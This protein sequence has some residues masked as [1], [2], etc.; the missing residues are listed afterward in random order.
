MVPNHAA[1]SGSRQAHGSR[2][3]RI[4]TIL[5]GVRPSALS[6]GT[7]FGRPE[8]ARASGALGLCRTRYAPLQRL[9]EHAH[10]EPYLCLA[11]T[12]SFAERSQGREFEVVPGTVVL[13]R[14]GE[15]HADRF[16]PAPASCLNVSF[17]RA[18][19][20][21]L[22]AWIDAGPALYAPRAALGEIGARLAREFEAPDEASELALEGLTLELLAFFTRREHGR[23]RRAPPWM[24]ALCERLRQGE[25]PSLL[26][27]ASE[28]GVH[29]A[30]L[31]RAFRR[32]HGC[33][34]GEYARRARLA[35]AMT[36]LRA[37]DAPLSEVA[38]RTGFA[39]QSH[40]TRALRAAVGLAPA[41]YRRATRGSAAG[42]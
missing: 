40:L 19:R 37:S 16:G 8:D 34:P 3:R 27:L 12:G 18:W 25:R 21:R 7:Y 9:P 35:R 13:H 26:T 24:P 14:A 33:S 38:L 41:A 31:V 20:E 39:D 17:P 42:A 23:E 32:Q 30:T 28:A 29:P 6:A 2:P 11:L 1:V 10:D 36:L 4:A 5:G 15:T 22:G